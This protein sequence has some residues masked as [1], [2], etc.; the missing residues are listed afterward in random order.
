MREEQI[1]DRPTPLFIGEGADAPRPE[2]PFTERNAVVAI[3]RN[4]CT[5]KYLGL[6]WKSVDWEALVTGGIESGQGAVEA[7]RTEILEET[8]YKHLRLVTQLPPVDAKFFHGPK[9]ENRFAHF[10][11]LVFEL[12]DD[13]RDEVASEEIARHDHVWLD[14]EE[15]LDFRL[16]AVQRFLIDQIL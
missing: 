11:T 4:P 9:N 14:S 13:E 16:P 15:L 2:L 10:Q 3:V 6:R 1:G 5:G 12:T 7:A 8:G